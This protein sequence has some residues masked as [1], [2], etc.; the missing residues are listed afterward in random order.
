MLITAPLLAAALCIPASR[1]AA[2]A[3]VMGEALALADV[4]SAERLACWLAQ[5][6]HETMRL[7]LVRELWGPTP[8][9]LRYEPCTTLSRTLGNVAAGDGRR[10][11]GRGL[12]QVTGRGNH[13]AT[14]AGLRLL[15]GADVPDFEAQPQ[16]LEQPRWAALSAAL[17]W[18]NRGLN[19]W[20]D[21][22]DFVTL[23][24]RINGGT[25]GLADRQALRAQ[26]WAAIMAGG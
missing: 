16:A 8:A 1:A 18:R 4:S 20:A 19:A 24:R 10:F 22:G 6:G 5:V 7:R 23:T 13:R 21:S 12:I 25:N 14:T 2:W 26:A 17:Y 9:Q 3:P 15:L 11:L